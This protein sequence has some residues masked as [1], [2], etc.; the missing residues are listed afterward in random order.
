MDKILQQKMESYKA[1]ISKLNDS[2]IKYQTQDT[3]EQYKL[4]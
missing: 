3:V 1:E 4:D 2:L